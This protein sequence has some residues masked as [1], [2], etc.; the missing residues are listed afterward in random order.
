MNITVDQIRESAHK[1]LNFV[2]ATTITEVK[3]N[4]TGVVTREDGIQ[5]KIR[6]PYADAKVFKKSVIAGQLGAIYEN[7][8]AR[9]AEKDGVAP[10]ESK[11]LPWGTMSED[12]FF[13]HHKGEDYLRLIVTRSL[14]APVFFLADGTVINKEDI[15]PFIPAQSESSTQEN[16]SKKIVVRT[17]KMSSLRQVRLGKESLDAT[18]EDHRDLLNTLEVA[19]A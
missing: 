9:Q 4:K 18:I 2:G 6:N 11:P 5:E 3:L 7:A 19:T 17:Y 10:H 8:I 13:I 16:L 12:R 14:E 15:A 1:G